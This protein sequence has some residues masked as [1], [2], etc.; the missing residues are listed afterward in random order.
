MSSDVS[1]QLGNSRST[2]YRLLNSWEEEGYFSDS[3]EAAIVRKDIGICIEAEEDH[4]TNAKAG[5]EQLQLQASS[6]AVRRRLNAE[7]IHHHTPAKKD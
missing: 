7:G 5:R 4:F 6:S 1:E 2:V 3:P